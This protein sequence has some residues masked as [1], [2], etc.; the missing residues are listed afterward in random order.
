MEKGGEYSTVLPFQVSSRMSQF[1]FI[2]FFSVD[3]IKS[4]NSTYPFLG[5]EE[6][7]CYMQECAI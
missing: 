7:Q 5:T 2:A 3:T 4:A 1:S 6:K